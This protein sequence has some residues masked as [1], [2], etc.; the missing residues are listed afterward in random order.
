MK[1]YERAYIVLTV[2]P[3]FG[4]Y[5]FEARVKFLAVVQVTYYSV[6][7]IGIRFLW[8]LN[9]HEIRE[10]FIKFNSLFEGGMRVLL[11]ACDCVNVISEECNFRSHC[12]QFRQVCTDF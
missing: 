3:I 10:V 6:R 12:M 7:Y 8:N 9:S 1:H 4:F 2:T 5:S 11:H